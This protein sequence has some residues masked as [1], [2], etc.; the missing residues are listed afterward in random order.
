MKSTGPAWDKYQD[1]VSK[2]KQNQMQMQEDL[3]SNVGFG[4]WKEFR[5]C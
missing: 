5:Q 1:P 3:G 4:V 2:T